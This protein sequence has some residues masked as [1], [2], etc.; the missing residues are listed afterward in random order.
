MSLFE[1]KTKYK[2]NDC[3]SP[4]KH[5]T[6]YNEGPQQHQGASFFNMKNEKR[7]THTYF[8]EI[9]PEQKVSHTH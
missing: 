8:F 6:A 5:I 9:S 1:T 4:M 7:V 3:C 2:K